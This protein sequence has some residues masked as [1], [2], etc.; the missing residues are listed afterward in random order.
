MSVLSGVVLVGGVA[1]AQPTGGDAAPAPAPAAGSGSAEGSAVAP[2]E[3]APPSDMEGRD[4]NPDAPRIS[5]EPVVPTGPAAPVKKS[6]YPIE[7]VQ[8]PITLP[9]NMGEVSIAPHFQVS[10][11][12]GSDALRF[13]FGITPKVQ[14]GLTYVYG[15]LYDDPLDTSDKVGFHAGKAGGLDVTV[16]VQNWLGVKVRLPVYLDP[17]AMSFAAGAPMKFR[18]GKVAIG[19]MEDVLNIT[20]KRFPPSLYQEAYN[21]EGASFDMTHSQQ[22]R[23]RLRF[24]GYA[25]YQQSP[26]LAL[27]GRIGLDRDLGAGGGG[28]AGTST[29]ETTQTFIRGGVQFSP[30]RFLDVGASVGFDNLAKAGSFGLGGFFALR[31]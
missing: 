21:A 29:V 25:E 26:K 14:L 19:G 28:A 5:D 30:R 16:L 4:E 24:S 13:R 8:R 23:G 1:M 9:Q 15:G 22:S 20:I 10:P 7:E 11:F 31:I 3:D 27:I 17:F 18:F 12:A 6:G 2:I